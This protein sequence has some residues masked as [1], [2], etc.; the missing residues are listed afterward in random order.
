MRVRV[1][2]LTIGIGAKLSCSLKISCSFPSRSSPH[3]Q[4]EAR[5][6][7][8]ASSPART[9]SLSSETVS[10]TRR[11]PSLAHHVP[12]LGHFECAAPAGGRGR[13]DTR[14]RASSS[15]A[16]TAARA[17]RLVA[18]ELAAA[19]AEVEAAETVDAARAA[20]T[21]F[22]ALCGNSADS[23]VSGDDITN[24]ELR[25]AREAAQEQAAQWAAAHP[26]WGRARRHPR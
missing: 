21:E 19:R 3:T 26:P 6:P 23:S 7:I 10:S 12:T 4:S 9:S 13:R 14:T 17:A 2:L 22:K 15:S 18:A 16:T 25:L 24:D 11:D 20:M 1:S 8:V 5:A